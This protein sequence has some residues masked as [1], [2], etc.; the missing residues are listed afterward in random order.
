MHR[1]EA[2]AQQA[3]AKQAAQAAKN[4]AS[5]KAAAQAAQEAAVK[6]A[7]EAAIA[8]AQQAAAQAA[9]ERAAQQA[10]QRQAEAEARAQ[11]EAAAAAAAAQA[12]AEAEAQRQAEA[13]AAA[14]AAAEAEA[15]RQAEAA[16]A[17]AASYSNSALGQQIA[18][19]A[20]MWV[21]GPYVSGGTS[22]TNGCDCAGFVKAVY[23]N[24]GYD[25]IQD[26]TM[27]G[28]CYGT[29]IGSVAEAQPGDIICYVGG[30]SAIYIGNNTI[31]NASNP[32]YGICVRS[33]ANYRTILAIARLV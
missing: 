22:L 26:P 12:E 21:G 29:P 15:Q 6:A 14:Q 10:A 4:D 32:E 9:A 13:E 3:I 28:T 7:Q 33:P 23:A 2:A 20:C 8:Q 30:H 18:D 27:Q 5:Q 11:A 24:F 16:A 25:L 19:F 31:V 1:A 17:A